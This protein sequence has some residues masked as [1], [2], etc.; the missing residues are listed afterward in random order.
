MKIKNRSITRLHQFTRPLL[1]L[2]LFLIILALSARTTS[3]HGGGAPQLTNESI[4]PYWI[5]VWTSPQPVREGQLHVTV[6]L[7]EPGEGDDQQA[8]APV[9]GATVEVTLTPRSGGF[10]DIR[11]TATNEQAAN[12]LFY[13]TDLMVPAAGDWEVEIAVRGA[14]GSGQAHFSLA[15]QPAQDTGWLLL[16]GGAFAIIAVFFLYYAARRRS[17]D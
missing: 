17:H 11:A 2:V 6:A 15:V 5:S 12:K 7:A 9:L 10:A 16:A 3:A 8:G 4:G 13:E 14:E 1:I